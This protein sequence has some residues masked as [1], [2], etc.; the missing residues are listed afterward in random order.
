MGAIAVPTTGTH[1]LTRCS[2]RDARLLGRKIGNVIRLGLE[3]LLTSYITVT[4]HPVIGLTVLW[5]FWRLDS[6]R[7]RVGYRSDDN[8]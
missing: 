2:M 7:E 1:G 4:G 5:I 8:A 6:L 3:A